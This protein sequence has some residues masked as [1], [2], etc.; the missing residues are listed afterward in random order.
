MSAFRKSVGRFAD[1]FAHKF[2]TKPLQPSSTTTTPQI[3]TMATITLRNGAQMPQVGFGLWKVTE[4]TAK[5]VKNALKTGY[6]LLDG[7]AGK[8]LPNIPT[9][10]NAY[11]RQSI[12]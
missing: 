4:N 1:L 10:A 7:A 5:T 2:S 9:V 6:R 8:S 3:R 11:H 12:D